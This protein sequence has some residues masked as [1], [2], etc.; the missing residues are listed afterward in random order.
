MKILMTFLVLLIPYGLIWFAAFRFLRKD[1]KTV[2]N[3]SVLILLSFIG[4]IIYYSLIFFIA[5]KI[6]PEHISNIVGATM[7]G[8]AMIGYLLIIP[9]FII[10]TILTIIHFVNRR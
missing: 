9:S 2:L 8:T 4:L 10:T 3:Y 1:I 7:Y 6:L 5:D